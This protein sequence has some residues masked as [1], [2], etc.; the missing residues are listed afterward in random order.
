MDSASLL[1][2]RRPFI[3]CIADDV[4]GATD[5]AINLAQGGVRV[6]QLLGVPSAGL[7]NEVAAYDAVVIALKTRSIPAEQAIDRSLEALKALQQLGVERFYFKYCSTF[8]STPDG[9]IGPVAEALMDALGVE[10]TVYC[11]AFPR[12]G[13]TVYRGHL[14]VGDRLLNESGMENHPL[15]PMTDA[16]LVRVL[17]AQTT[18]SVGLVGYPTPVANAEAVRDA[19]ASVGGRQAHLI[20]DACDDS[21]LESIAKAVAD[22][23]LVTGG[24][25]LARYLPPAYVERG[26][27][28]E[29]A[30]LSRA[31][32]VAGRSLV[33]AGS[34][35]TAT[36]AQ[37]A[38][39]AEQMPVC[40]VDVGALMHEPD[41]E[42][43]RILAW[44]GS[45]DSESPLLIASTDTPD[46]VRSLQ[47]SYDP[48]A[49]ATAIET[50]M[51]SLAHRMTEHEGVRRV[52]VAGGETSGAV[53]AA[54]EI[55]ALEI[56]PEIAPGVPW[57]RTIGRDPELAVAFKS[58]NF[59][60]SDFFMSALEMLP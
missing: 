16:D 60:G 29:A 56:G 19:I 2:D 22:L 39:A 44:A 4:T 17:S 58:G 26:L 20:V 10:T 6:V 38:A 7:L 35:S 33:L 47:A 49:V 45:Q 43:R 18:R 36:Q 11:P 27:L 30:A 32:E 50:L 14:F 23:R 5:L 3:G 21:H 55:A 8:D 40:R 31:P 37:V 24:S 57:T 52:I 9:N 34:C 1:P 41:A 48:D 12:A 25:G 54:L 15:N 51:G 46:A 59:G 13:R 42:K 53:A 28:S